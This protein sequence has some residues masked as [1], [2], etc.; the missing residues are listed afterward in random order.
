MSDDFQVEYDLKVQ[1]VPVTI[2]GTKYLLRE[3]SEDAACQYRNAAMRGAKMT[4]GTVTLG[5]AAD[6]E[7]LLVSLCLFEMDASGAVIRNVPLVTVKNWPARVV[8][9][10]FNK[11]KEMSSLDETPKAKEA[12]KN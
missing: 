11:V 3:A 2:G 12:A 9:P 4:D 6:V 5:G 7:P 8:K 1:E 10:L